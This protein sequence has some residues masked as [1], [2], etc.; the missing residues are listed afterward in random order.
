MMEGIKIFDSATITSIW[1]A[2]S[3]EAKDLGMQPN[4]DGRYEAFVKN[5]AEEIIE[6][7]QPTY[8]PNNRTHWS[9]S[10]SPVIRMMTMFGSARSKI[11]M[12]MIERFNAYLMNPNKEN[13]AKLG[14][15]Y[16]NT[17]VMTSIMLATINALKNGMVFGFDDEEE[18]MKSFGM[19]M[20][21]SSAGG[22]YGLSDI[23]RMVASR[24]DDAPWTANMEH[25]FA[26]LSGAYA[27]ATA[28]LVKGDMNKFVDKG[29]K[30]V[31]YSTGLSAQ[32]MG[33][34]AKGLKS[35]SNE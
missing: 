35:L 13:L 27:D 29:F 19:D 32:V 11:G 3:L 30:A 28:A 16:M 14:K 24:I 9:H 6:V 10:N 33:L 12:I 20:V 7:T 17:V 23:T 8:D 31:S 5:K 2:V 21:V 4:T 18:L 22:F 15:A 34:P 1:R 25:P 26:S